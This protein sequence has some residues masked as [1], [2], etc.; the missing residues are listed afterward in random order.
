MRF[1]K[2]SIDAN[3]YFWDFGDGNG[4]TKTTPLHQHEFICPELV[5]LMAFAR[6]QGGLVFQG[7]ISQ[8]ILLA[9]LNK[10]FVS[11]AMTIV[12]EFREWSGERKGKKS[13]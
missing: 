9:R 4:S 12:G 3:D 1:I 10:I 13:Q 6:Y 8:E 5:T 2:L 11:T 7:N